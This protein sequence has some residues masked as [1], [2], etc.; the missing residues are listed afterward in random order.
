MKLG[1]YGSNGTGLEILEIAN[2]INEREKRWEEVVFID[3]TK[4]KGILRN[5]KIMPFI[6]FNKTYGTEDTEVVIAVG[7]PTS[8][9]KLR[10]KLKENGYKLAN[11]IHPNSFV[12]ESATLG[13]GIVVKMQSIVF[14][15]AHIADNVFIQANVVV[16]HEVSI[17][18]DC[19]ISAFAHICGNVQI[20]SR[21]FLGAQS[22]IREKC[23]I[24]DD[25]VVAMGSM[26]MNDMEEETMAIGNPAKFIRRKKG[27]KVF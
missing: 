3:D 23:K 5:C 20:G 13:E 21:V 9:Q 6:D 18:E 10:L 16:G 22:G 26:V 19:Q 11:I 12:S 25:C 1:I 2:L 7:E 14:S 27:S 15:D 17:G 24:G 8:K 4:D